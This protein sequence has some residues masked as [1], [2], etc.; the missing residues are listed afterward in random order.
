MKNKFTILLL[1]G[2]F[3]YFLTS[4]LLHAQSLHAVTQEDKQFL[5]TAA[6]LARGLNS[7]NARRLS[8]LK[9][10]NRSYEK[11]QQATKLFD[12]PNASEEIIELLTTA[13]KQY[14][15]NYLSSLFLGAY[16]YGHQNL[17]AAAPYF[18]DFLQKSLFPSKV[19]RELITDEETTYFRRFIEAA[20]VKEGYS[21]KNPKLP[22]EYKFK[23][24]L[25]RLHVFP[26]ESFIGA[27]LTI[28]VFIGFA[29]ILFNSIFHVFDPHA[30]P[31]VLKQGA[32]R[33]YCVCV[34]AYVTWLIHLYF[35]IHP[36]IGGSLVSEIIFILLLGIA[37]VISH[38]VYAWIKNKIRIKNDPDLIICPHCKRVQSRLAAICTDCKKRIEQ[39]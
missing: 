22:M 15:G 28:I 16:H 13:Q 8:P 19:E 2:A 25:H 27:L 9:A 17:N 10:V 6:K 14:K 18:Q 24:G 35:G 33:I 4:S 12:D 29:F 20:L 38:L 39:V 21:L 32:F 34:I 37:L 5:E 30:T 7:K 11:T 23:R 31:L 26:E 3:F 36:V 1:L